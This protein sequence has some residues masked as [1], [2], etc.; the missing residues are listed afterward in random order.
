MQERER[1]KMQDTLKSEDTEEA[2]D[3]WFYRPLGFR[4]ALLARGLG[5]TPNQ[6]TITSI[7]IGVLAGLFF[8]PTNLMVNVIGML[9]LVVA[10]LMDS[11]DGQ[12]ARL[13]SNHT[14]LGRILDG[15]A[16]D[17]WFICIYI[18]CVLRLIN[19]GFSS[20][21]W[22][23]GS[24]AGVSHI[25]HA[26][27]ADYYRNIH[28]YIIKS[29][30][31]SEHDNSRA[32]TETLHSI[33]FRQKPMEKIFMWFYRNYTLQQEMLSPKMQVFLSELKARYGDTLPQ[34]LRE[35]LRTANK[36]NMPLTNIL[37]FNTRVIFLF[38]C[39]F[40]NCVW[41]YFVFDLVVL[42][43][44]LIVLIL[45]EERFA[46]SFTEVLRQNKNIEG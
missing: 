30:E 1:P 8:Y 25:L 16:G 4:C 24:A 38:F 26:A 15:L 28:L 34:S 36:G 41:L 3:I 42:N 39:L 29:S 23:L 18:V 20:W 10:N 35:R 46:K 33:P 2:L 7:F 14:R 12:L 21:V 5:I 32:I 37:Q 22:L 6:I 31:G 43:A 44:V 40:W 45:R 19:E 13:T 17:M 9:L 27:M 11:T